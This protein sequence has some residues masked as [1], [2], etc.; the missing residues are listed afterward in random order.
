MTGTESPFN[1]FGFDYIY[2]SNSSESTPSSSITPVAHL[3]HAFDLQDDGTYCLFGT[4]ETQ[5]ISG[6]VNYSMKIN[7]AEFAG[8]T[9]TGKYL[10]LCS[11]VQKTL[12]AGANTLTI[13]FWGDGVNNNTVRRARAFVWINA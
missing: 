3:N 9:H 1:P 13:E 12:S 2:G 10:T 5:C 6:E 11:I 4:I 7:G 8:G